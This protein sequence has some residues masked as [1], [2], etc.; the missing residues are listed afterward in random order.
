MRETC[1]GDQYMARKKKYKPESA[2]TWRGKSYK[3]GKGGRD[4]Q[5]VREMRDE[6]AKRAA[7]LRRQSDS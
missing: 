1:R 3:R 6:D 7:R 5:P 2:R 4:A